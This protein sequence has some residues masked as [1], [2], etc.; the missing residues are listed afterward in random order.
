ML[1]NDINGMRR[2]SD[3]QEFFELIKPFE[4]VP[5]SQYEGRYNYQ[6]LYHQE[7][8]SF[9]CNHDDT[10]ACFGYERRFLGV[11]LLWIDG[12]C[13]RTKKDVQAKQITAFYNELRSFGFDI[14]EVVSNVPYNFE[15]EKA[16]RQA[17]FLRPIGQFSM[18]LTK[19]ID[20]QKELDYVGNW[21]RNLK[22]ADKNALSL[23]PCLQPTPKECEE[24]SLL[25]NK[26]I[27]RKGLG[28][29]ISSEQFFALCRLGD[30]RMYF[31]EHEGKK[32]AGTIIHQR[33][34]YAGSW[35]AATL[36]EGLHLSA[37]FFMYREM[38]LD[39]KARG[40][41]YF[42]L[43]KL[44]PSVKSVDKVFQFKD[45]IK[46]EYQQL[47]GEW[48]WYKN[49]LLRLLTYF[50]KKYIMRKREM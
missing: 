32:V 2:I 48:A 17:G 50:L 46:G 42:D 22:K 34:S 13:Y 6:A 8:F 45:G 1:K 10:I 28:R 9:F 5:H 36:E 4:I 38:M 37:S 40:Y 30:Y 49:S 41:L 43:E 33:N 11:R 3:K 19:I 39:L 29:Q 47:N 44:V 26:M 23:L 35:F 21:K 7:R 31:V 16:M 25:Y 18:P 12:E 14:I 24:F 27:D 20:L 15:Y